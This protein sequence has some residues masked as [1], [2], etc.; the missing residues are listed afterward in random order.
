LG[1]AS[2]EIPWNEAKKKT[3]TLKKAAGPRRIRL[4]GQRK[5]SGWI[6]NNERVLTWD[7]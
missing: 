3:V 1:H 5:K 2:R 4:R 6:G 7:I